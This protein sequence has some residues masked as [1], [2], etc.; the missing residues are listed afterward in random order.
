MSSGA[1]VESGA[2][3]PGAAG[4]EENGESE[5]AAPA[6]VSSQRPLTILQ[7]TPELNAGGVERGT[8]EIAQAVVAAGGRALVAS[9]GGR[10]AARL[11]VHGAQSVILP[12]ATKNPAQ[13]LLNAARLTRLIRRE[14]VDIV[15]ARSRAPAWSGHLA[16]RRTGVRFITTYHGTYSENF[17]G[18]KQ[19]NAVMAK[20]DP[21]IAISE[22]IAAHVAARHGVPPERIEVIPRGADLAVFNEAKTSAARVGALAEAWGLADDL[23]PVFM[24]PGRLTRWKGQT[25]FLDALALLKARLGAEAFQGVLVGGE[26]AEGPMGKFERELRGRIAALGLQDVAR[27]VG[28]CDDMPAAYRLAGYAVS[29]SL[30]PEAFGRVAVEAQA[31]GAPVIAAA[32]GGAMETVVDGETG[33]RFEPGSA[34]ALAAAMEHALGVSKERRRAM[35]EAGVAL[36]RARF[37]VAAMQA[38]TLAVYEKAAGRPF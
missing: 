9:A 18:K 8:L 4:G 5:F 11:R 32:H 22:F 10:L 25:L 34:E 33:W 14:G 21:V 12:L 36:V 35:A 3:P 26:A 31:M 7:L 37:S 38:A 16:A 24:L 28:H 30:E 19:Y 17:P 2:T 29:A 27:L 1:F 13:M 6:T 15:H 23:R 20:G